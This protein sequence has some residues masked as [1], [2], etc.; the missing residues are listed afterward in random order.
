MTAAV[1]TRTPTQT[2]RYDWGLISVVALLLALGLVMV[3]SASYAR[4]LVGF[5]D[6]YYFAIRQLI[7]GGI[8]VVVMIVAA[9]IPYQ[10]WERGSVPLMG[11]GLLA[12]VTVLV[13][14]ADRFGSTRTYF[15]GSVQPSEPVKV[16]VILYVGAWLASKGSRIRDVRVGLLP[17]SVLMGAISVLI[18]AQPE[19]STAILIV[20]SAGIMF[21][22]AGAELKQLLLIL[23]V[24]ATTFGLVLNYSSYASGRL[25]RYWASVWDPM[26]SEEYQVQRSVEALARGGPLG[27]GVGNGDA[28]LPG[29]LPLTWSD[30][31]FA[32]VGEELGL[33]GALVVILLFAL[34][35]YR[36]LRIALRAPDNFGMLVAVGITSSLILQAL[37]NTAVIVAA[38][39]PTGVTLPFMSYGGSSLVT[40][41]G[42][43]G[44]L[45]SISYYGTA[46][47]QAS[48][49]TAQPGKQAYASFDFGWRNRGP[50]LSSPGRRRPAAQPSRRATAPKRRT[51][52]A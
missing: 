35:A 38:A 50:R 10:W 4:G 46:R 49:G 9:R 21:F 41:L 11:V 3:F 25:D 15:G 20:A 36:G 28:Q 18:V 40:A 37:L 47:P 30:N 44:I 43:V 8:G 16:I 51:Q 27:V 24:G 12:L 42:A 23:V 7:W 17:F 48:G 39:P 2:R 31:I 34:L 14:G 45:L 19:V 29:Y 6:P 13:F 5:E 32:V 33:L 22:I 26:Q 1:R 52:R